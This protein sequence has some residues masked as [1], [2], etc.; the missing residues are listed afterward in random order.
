MSKLQAEVK[1]SLRNNA[2]ISDF[3]RRRL[4]E[5]NPSTPV[6]KCQIKLHKESNLIRLKVS[7]IGSPSELVKMTS[8]LLK[9]KY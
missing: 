3:E 1:R 4:I 6:L 2:E 5:S 8:K 7:F 9:E